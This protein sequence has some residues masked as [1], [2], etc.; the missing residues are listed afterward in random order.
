[1]DIDDCV[2]PE[3]I[4]SEF[5]G[6]PGEPPLAR[7]CGELF[8]Q[9]LY[10]WQ[11]FATA[12]MEMNGA[13]LR[14]LNAAGHTLLAQY[15]PG[16][17]VSATAAVDA[18]AVRRRPC[19]LC[20]DRLPAAQRAVR[21]RGDFLILVNPRP[22][23]SPHFT[24]AHVRHLPQRLAGHV[25]TLLT[26]A[27]DLGNDFTVFYNGPRCGASAPDHHHFQVCPADAVPV[28]KE[29]E[30]G[31]LVRAGK[32]TGVDFALR[33]L[34]G[35]GLVVMEGR[36]EGAVAA[37]LEELIAALEPGGERGGE[38]ALFNL[39]TTYRDGLWRLFL[40]PRRKHRPDAYYREGDDALLVTPG[41][42]E[43]GGLII[44]VQERDFLR[45]TAPLVVEILGE[46]SLLAEEVEKIGE[47]F[48]IF[49]ASAPQ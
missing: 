31:R 19:F 9:Q 7:R 22:I 15:N 44:T 33:D 4:W 40:F 10:N 18:S 27:K 47:I 2:A 32:R 29:W 23:F 21:Y 35:R 34:P 1:M 45:M 41:A 25:R 14:E 11:E 8:A 24:V 46:V 16:R 49:T 30:K 13:W 20:P 37:L 43:M 26:L 5:T 36:D 6:M 28:E 3:Q 39:L 38:E 48:E 42:V 17:A 12:Y